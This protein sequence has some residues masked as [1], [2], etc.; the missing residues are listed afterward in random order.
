L[1]INYDCIA[2][3]LYVCND[4]GES[5]AHSNDGALLYVVNKLLHTVKSGEYIYDTATVFLL[6]NPLYN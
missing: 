1:D 4:A 5:V 2:G 6:C 3:V